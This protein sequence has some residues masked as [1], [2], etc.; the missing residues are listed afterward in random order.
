MLDVHRHL[1]YAPDLQSGLHK[2]QTT[3]MFYQKPN[4]INMH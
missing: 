4:K 1:A 3:N 2:S